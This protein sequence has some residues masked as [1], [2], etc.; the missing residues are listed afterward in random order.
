MEM[1]KASMSLMQAFFSSSLPFLSR[2][3]S[4]IFTTSPGFSRISARRAAFLASKST[5]GRGSFTL[6]RP[7]AMLSYTVML[8]HRA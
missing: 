8:G 7:K 6:D 3:S 1:V 2:Q 5:L 4:R